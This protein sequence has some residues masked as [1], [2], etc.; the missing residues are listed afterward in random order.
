MRAA[1]GAEMGHAAHA[2]MVAYAC[3][4]GGGM[5]LAPYAAK[6]VYACSGGG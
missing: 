2:A 5:G 1:V 6:V 4:G 3:S